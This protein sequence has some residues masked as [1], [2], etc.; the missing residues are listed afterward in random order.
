[1]LVF[2]IPC[3]LG[4]VITWIILYLQNKFE[5]SVLSEI[6]TTHVNSIEFIANKCYRIM[7]AANKRKWKMVGD[8]SQGFSFA[9]KQY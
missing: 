4:N 8:N 2:L 1:M 5:F 9:H 7:N 3:S 6:L